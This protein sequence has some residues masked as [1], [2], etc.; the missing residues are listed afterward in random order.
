M[1][2]GAIFSAAATVGTAVL[3]IVVSS[4]SMKDATATNHGTR[5]LT[6][7]PP[8]GAALSLTGVASL[9]SILRRELLHRPGVIVAATDRMVAIL[10]RLRAG[11]DGLGFVEGRRF[12]V[13]FV[14]GGSF[15]AKVLRVSLACLSPLVGVTHDAL[16]P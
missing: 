9:G 13:L 10:R 11:T 6:G 3:R 7:S 15:G 2:S 5:R 8:A 12:G 16:P 14:L 1:L 4:D